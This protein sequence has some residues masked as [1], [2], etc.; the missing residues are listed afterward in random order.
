M[1][2]PHQ[3]PDVQAV[4]AEEFRALLVSRRSLERLRPFP[5]R[6]LRRTSRL[7]DRRTGVVYLWSPEPDAQR[8]DPGPFPVGAR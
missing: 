2:D 5:P 6:D 4:D 8:R 1:E 7:R 3:R